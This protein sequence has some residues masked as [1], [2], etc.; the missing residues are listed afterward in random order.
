MTNPSSTGGRAV[1]AT[2]GHGPP[3]GWT[4]FSAVERTHGPAL[5]GEVLG[6]RFELVRPIGE[7]GMS[8]VYLARDRQL[9]RPVA[10][11][12]LRARDPVTEQRFLD[13]IELLARRSTRRT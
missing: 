10:V 5:A 9:P 7:G 8:V 3:R 1:G 12:V 6:R 2:K 13:E 4:L 11:K